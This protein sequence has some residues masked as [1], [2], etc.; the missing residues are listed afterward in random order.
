MKEWLEK[1]KIF[2]EEAAALT[3]KGVYWLACFNAQQAAE[4]YLKAIIIKRTG[5]HP[6]THDLTVLLS[7][8][9]ELGLKVP[10]ELHVYA[11]ALTPHYTMARYPGR[12]PIEYGKEI[13]K[14]C[15]KYARKIEEWTEKILKE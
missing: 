6:F 7:E 13:A 11:D 12:K 9:E 5:L 15:V 3:A 14:R 2:L 10:A 1:A 8:I 4:L